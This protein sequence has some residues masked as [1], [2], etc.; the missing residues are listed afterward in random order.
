MLEYRKDMGYYVGC[1]QIQDLGLPYSTILI[2]DEEVKEDKKRVH[3]LAGSYWVRKNKRALGYY[4]RNGAVAEIKFHPNGNYHSCVNLKDQFTWEE[5]VC[6]GKGCSCSRE[7][8]QA[9]CYTD[10][11]DTAF[12][13]SDTRIADTHYWSKDWTS[14]PYPTNNY[15]P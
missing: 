13:L 15:Q 9:V 8:K 5:Q 4:S 10:R 1:T 6:Y 7:I 14:G 11:A 3:S 2:K 12:F